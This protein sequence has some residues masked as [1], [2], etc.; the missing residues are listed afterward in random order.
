MQ[1]GSDRHRVFVWGHRGAPALLAENTLP[2][3][4]AALAGR[5]DGIELDVQLAADNT[6]VVLHDDAV[7]RT[8]D[9]HG[10]VGTFTWPELRR[11]RAKNPDGS[12]SPDGVPRL[13]DVLDALPADTKFCV[14]YKNGPHFYPELVPR[15]LAIIAAHRAEDRVMVSSFDQFALRESARLAPQVD[16]AAAWGMARLLEPWTVAAAVG[17]KFV[18]LHRAM[19]PVA[20]LAA[21]RAHALRI[22]VWSLKSAADVEQLPVDAIDAVFVDDPAW[23]A[24]LRRTAPA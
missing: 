14:E 17:A 11:L 8:T 9:G 15:T 13:E 3:F 21:M 22:A 7:D 16:R 2:S 4:A 6:V 24:S 20:D 19:A 18:H 1:T 10:W 5:V 12:W 23:A